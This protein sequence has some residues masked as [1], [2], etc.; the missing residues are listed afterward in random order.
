MLH[1]RPCTVPY[2]S[3]DVSQCCLVQSSEIVS[4]KQ[5]KAV[6]TAFSSPGFV[7]LD[8]DFQPIAF[9]HES[10]QIL[11][12]PTKPE[13]IQ[14]PAIFLTDRIRSRLLKQ[15]GTAQLPFVKEYRSGGR[16]YICRSFRVDGND[17]DQQLIRIA[18]L[19]ERHCSSVNVLGDTLEQFELTPDRKSVV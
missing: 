17:P 15:N 2:S 16:Q 4:R 5:R 14:Q 18:L 10:I 9:N 8:E 19:L 1:V 3:L 6:T 13:R 7:L 12:F 11:A